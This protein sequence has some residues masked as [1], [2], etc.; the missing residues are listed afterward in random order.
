M[1][2][3]DFEAHFAT[4][5]FISTLSKN[6]GYPRIAVEKETNR[7]R[8]Y[9]SADAIEPYSDVL[10]G[11]LLDLGENRIQ[12]MDTAG[13]DVQVLTLLAPG[14]EHFDPSTGTALAKRCNDFLSETMNK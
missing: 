14:V 5:E 7:R 1:R 8:F 13:V 11:R 2:R 9:F 10:L 4:E 6:E 3:I 12:D